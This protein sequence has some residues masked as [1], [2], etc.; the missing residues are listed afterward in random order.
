MKVCKHLKLNKNP[1]S[2]L[3]GFRPLGTLALFLFVSSFP[4]QAVELQETTTP[5]TF[6]DWCLNKNNL[7]VETLHTINALLQVAKTTDC[8]QASKLLSA[9]S[10][11]SL[12]SNQIAD[13]K[14]L[15]TL[16]NLTNL[17]L[18]SNQ[19]A[20]L[21]PLSTLTNLTGLSLNKN[22]IA[23]LK[24]LSGLTNLNVL[25]LD[26]NQ[27]TDLKPLSGL[28]NLIGIALNKNRIAD[29]KPLSGLTNL[30]ELWLNDNQIADL[31]PLS[32]LTN[33][34]RLLLANNQTL[35]DKTCPVKP[36]SICRFYRPPSHR[37]RRAI[38]LNPRQS[39]RNAIASITLG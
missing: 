29:L 37:R 23:D 1:A 33:L 2:T 32:G 18:D 35:T 16:T 19:I 4:V 10:E 7:S 17:D 14:P 6:A 22:R 28:T 25:Y 21:K 9:L 34:T 11:L 13:L 12:S 30:T 20:D 31:K 3:P 36:A 38:P 27:I 5:R 15:S 39:L 8:N 24:P 26:D